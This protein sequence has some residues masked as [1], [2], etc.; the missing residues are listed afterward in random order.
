MRVPTMERKTANDFK[1]RGENR[2]PATREFVNTNCLRGDKARFRGGRS[3][4][5]GGTAASRAAIPALSSRLIFDVERIIVM[6]L[7]SQL[8]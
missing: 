1:G 5:P 3:L 6:I 2:R 8:T 4:N 7:F